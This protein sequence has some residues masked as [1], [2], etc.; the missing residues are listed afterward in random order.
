MG[1][2]IGLCDG[3]MLDFALGKKLYNQECLLDGDCVGY[4][5]GVV[6]EAIIGI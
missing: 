4:L 3:L 5:M 1:I 6:I 2:L